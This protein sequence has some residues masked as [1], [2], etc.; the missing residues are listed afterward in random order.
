MKKHINLYAP[1]SLEPPAGAW[2]ARLP[3]HNVPVRCAP[4]ALQPLHAR[5]NPTTRSYWALASTLA[6]SLFSVKLEHLEVWLQKNALQKEEALELQVEGQASAVA[7]LRTMASLNRLNACI[8]FSNLMQATLG[9]VAGCAW[10]DVAIDVFPSLA[11]TPTIRVL[12]GNI[13]ASMLMTAISIAYLVITGNAG[14]A[15]DLQNRAQVEKQFL[16]GAMSFFSGWGWVLVIRDLFY[17]LGGTLQSLID[18]ALG[19]P[20]DR[21]AGELLSVLIFAPVLT[22]LF[23]YTKHATITVYTRSIT[24]RRRLIWNHALRESAESSDLTDEVR[25]RIRGRAKRSKFTLIVD[26]A[27]QRNQGSMPGQM[28]R[29]ASCSV[30]TRKKSLALVAADPTSET[31]REPHECAA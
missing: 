14:A 10:T 4:C 23:F 20:A 31:M 1:T 29:R 25:E 16:T 11:G 3:A 2:S 26:A 13:G 30:S 17:P 19:Q 28:R 18:G 6:G 12:M 22:A 15:V 9:W 27:Q 21:R 7:S 5:C 24:V 8:E